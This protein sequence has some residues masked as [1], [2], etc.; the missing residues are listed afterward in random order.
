MLQIT[1]HYDDMAKWNTFFEKVK[2]FSLE[3][4]R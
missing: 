3:S 2:Q 1:C 4:E